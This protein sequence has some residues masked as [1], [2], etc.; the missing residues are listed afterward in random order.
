[1]LDSLRTHPRL[2]LAALLGIV[3]GLLLPQAWPQ[4][5][6]MIAGWD[7]AAGLYLVLAWIMILSWSAERVQVR[8]RVEDDGRWAILLISAG[9]AATSLAAIVSLLADFKDLPD[10]GKPL[11]LTLAVATILLSW[12]FLHTVFT[13]HYAHEFYGAAPDGGSAERKKTRGGFAFP[14][15]A[16]AWGYLDFAY[17]AFTIGMTAQ[18]SDIAVTTTAMRRLTLAHAILT[19]F[20][21]T[22]VLAFSVNIAASL[23]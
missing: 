4:G 1:M 19:F 11:H 20:F 10:A 23:L 5:M 16:K 13:I 22:V 21:N 6:R 9:A 18:T 17:Y 14:G 7:V 15:D 8:A 2:F 12:F 3:A